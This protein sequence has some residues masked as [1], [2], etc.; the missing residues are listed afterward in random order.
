MITRLFRMEFGRMVARVRFWVVVL[1]V[2]LFGA[3]EVFRVSPS[4]NLV[5]GGVE[6]VRSFGTFGNHVVVIYAFAVPVIAGLTSAGSLAADRSRR[7]ST[8]VLIRGVSGAQ[9]ILTKAAAMATAAA[10]ATFA[11]C[12]LTLLAA[13]I[14]LSWGSTA[15]SNDSAGY[16]IS[17]ELFAISPLL[18]D[19]FV[20][21]LV[22]LAS[23]ALALS[24]LVV[25][26]LVANEYVAAAVPFVLFLDATLL[27]GDTPP[28]GLLSPSFYLW[29]T[30]TYPYHL[31][32]AWKLF[33]APLYWSAF[34]AVAI[35]IG[36]AI[37]L[38]KEPD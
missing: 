31:S 12:A 35:A 13:V 22:S 25:G 33:A 34:C 38:R 7:Y 2:S 30:D 28:L 26:A 18:Y 37:F 11:S 19:L 23:A 29:L 8:L 5:L 3:Y 32:S 1:L 6:S 15:L 16:L 21:G 17:P 14:L 36:G 9:Y 27:T 24:G 10:L 20:A 4:G